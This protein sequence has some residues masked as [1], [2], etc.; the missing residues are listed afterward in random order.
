MH[1]QKI[2]PVL[3]FMGVSGCGKSTCGQLVA[4]QLGVEYA[5]GDAFHPAENVEKMRSGTALTD[6]D[7]APWLMELS[8]L[9]ARWVESGDGGV[10][11]CSALKRKYRD[12]LRGDYG[13]GGDIRFIHLAGPFEVIERRMAQRENHYM[14]PG[15]LASQFATLEEPDGDEKIVHIDITSTPEVLATEVLVRLDEDEL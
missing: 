5:E 11:S 9:L 6:A 8:S 2:S 12:V 10:L 15:L 4:R 14:P 13:I 3:V 1:K 7:R